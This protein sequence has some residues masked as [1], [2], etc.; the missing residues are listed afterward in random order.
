MTLGCARFLVPVVCLVAISA[1]S[2]ADHR[3]TGFQG[4][5]VK[6]LA[7]A[8][9]PLTWT[10]EENIA[11]SVPLPGYGQSSPVVWGERVFVTSVSGS[12][13][14][15]CHLC[16][17]SLESGKK[18]WQHDAESASQAKSTNYISKAAPTPVVDRDGITALFEVGNLVSLT[19]GGQLRWKR[20]L[21]ADYGALD[22]RHGL[23]SSLEQDEKSVFVWI[24]RQT[25]PY[26]LAIAKSTGETLWKVP[27]LGTTSW[28]S[29]RLV[30]VGDRFHLVLS[31]IGQLAGFDPQT[32]ERLWSF[33][34]I[35][36]NSTPTPVAVGNARFLIAATDGRGEQA[37]GN[38][39]SNGLI[40]IQQQ[41]D[42]S[43][44][45]QYLW[46]AKKATSSFGSPV[47]HQGEAYFVGRGG[48]VYCL[49]LE[50]GTRR[51]IKR[52][53]QSVWATPIAVGCRV[54][55]FGRGGTT[56]VVKAGQEFQQLAVNE[57]WKE[58]ANQ[59]AGRRS[60]FGGPVLYSAVAVKSKLLLRRGD[61][62]YCVTQ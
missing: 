29:P 39:A 7:E 33:D 5:P 41:K 11:W 10:P 55:F 49:D 56:T 46:Q 62:L 31:G 45:A 34:G 47:V 28:S 19:H 23:A 58:D 21:V 9:L 52:T 57:L 4:P 32:G 26:L 3:W 38:A 30:P 20:D 53:A 36:G 37:G 59:A 44:Q 12:M 27:A 2:R 18:L 61:R 42:G 6:T 13:K 50:T 43:F 1:D 22:S 48:V 14:E 15:K 17:F 40:E 25:E 35:S 24:E 16:A 54:Y 8:D 51:Y 60:P